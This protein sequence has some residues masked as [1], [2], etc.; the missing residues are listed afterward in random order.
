MQ[1]G[2]LKSF[3]PIYYEHAKTSAMVFQITIQPVAEL[4]MQDHA[5]EVEN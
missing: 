4:K 5:S 3:W 2:M 1:R